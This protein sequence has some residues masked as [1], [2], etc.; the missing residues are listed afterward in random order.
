ML[1][2]R[3]TSRGSAL[4]ISLIILILITAVTTVFLERIW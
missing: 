2:Y 3:G 4:L 1:F